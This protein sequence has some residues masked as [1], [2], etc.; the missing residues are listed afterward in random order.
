MPLEGVAADPGP[1][2]NTALRSRSALR[3]L[4]QFSFSARFQGTSVED[5]LY[6]PPF[7]PSPTLSTGDADIFIPQS[8]FDVFP[9]SLTLRLLSLP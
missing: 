5:N 8:I 4:F 6:A 1:P 9:V 7:G 2:A 3:V